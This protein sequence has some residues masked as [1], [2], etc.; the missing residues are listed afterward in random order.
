[1]TIAP[2][3][4]N[5]ILVQIL[6]GVIVDSEERVEDLS[7]DDLTAKGRQRSELHIRYPGLSALFFEL[8][9]D[10]IIREVV[11]WNLMDESPTDKPGLFGIPQAVTAA[12]EEQGHGTLHIDIL[13]WIREYNKSRES[14]FSQSRSERR[15]AKRNICEFVDNIAS[16]ELFSVKHCHN[17][18]AS[19]GAF[20]HPCTQPD[21][22]SKKTTNCC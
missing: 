17:K 22:K 7:D 14:L 6:S 2:D 11:G 5:S 18:Y 12:V 19:N 3:D 16:T 4:D 13:V 9:L 20:P 8:V 21:E 10:I 15:N 1:M